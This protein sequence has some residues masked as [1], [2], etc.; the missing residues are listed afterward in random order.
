MTCIPSVWVVQAIKS[1]CINGVAMTSY[2]IHLITPSTAGESAQNPLCRRKTKTPT[3]RKRPHL[4]AEK[5]NTRI[6]RVCLWEYATAA[7]SWAATRVASQL[8][9]CAASRDGRRQTSQNDQITT[10][11][12]ASNLNETF[13]DFWWRGADG[14]ETD[15]KLWH[16][17]QT[18]VDLSARSWRCCSEAV[19]ATWG[20][21]WVT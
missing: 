12:V 2:S 6:I 3:R 13:L 21:C 15:L 11:T 20:H 14:L 7:T 5:K 16:R 10:A 17:G 8:R 9:R 1:I 18:A 4:F 19:L